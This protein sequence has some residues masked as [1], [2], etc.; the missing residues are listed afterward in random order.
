LNGAE[1]RRNWS[2][3]FRVNEPLWNWW[4]VGGVLSKERKSKI[5]KGISFNLK[6][7]MCCMPKKK[8]GT[9][10]ETGHAIDLSTEK[11]LN[12]P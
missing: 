10:K 4:G 12:D 1:I 5:E 2:Q 11:D 7:V 9:L 3:Q 6:K 8:G